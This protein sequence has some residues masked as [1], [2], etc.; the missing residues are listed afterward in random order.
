VMVLLTQAPPAAPAAGGSAL[1]SALQVLSIAVPLLVAVVGGVFGYRSQAKQADRG[2]DVEGRKLTLAEYEALN[3]SLAAEIDR[4]RTDRR[5]DEE[6]M[7]TRLAALESRLESLEAERREHAVLADRME[8][9]LTRQLE[10]QRAWG[11]AVLRIVRTPAVVAFLEVQGMAIPPVPLGVDD[12][13][14][15]MRAVGSPTAG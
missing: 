2:A 6:R 13:D 10:T 4:I 1:S 12:T 14:P 3:R 5:E 15:G 11:R 9:E 7:A 8:R